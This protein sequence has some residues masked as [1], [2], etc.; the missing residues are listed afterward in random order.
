MADV[1]RLTPS[2]NKNIAPTLLHTE[3][4]LDVFLEDSK[5]Q[6]HVSYLSGRGHG[7]ALLLFQREMS[8]D[9]WKWRCN[10][11]SFITLTYLR[12]AHM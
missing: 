4:V 12:P 3:W 9:V 2:D 5:G 10:L 1:E 8:S 7:R 6:M 11:S